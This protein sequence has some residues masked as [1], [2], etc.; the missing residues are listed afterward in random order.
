MKT[1]EI[2]SLRFNRQYVTIGS[3]NV[4]VPNRRQAII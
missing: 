2:C 3:E 1:F 4:F